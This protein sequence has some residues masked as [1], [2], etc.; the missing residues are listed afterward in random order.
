MPKVTIDVSELHGKYEDEVKDL[1]GLLKSKA[2]GRV[3][4]IGSE[5]ILS[6]EE[7]EKPPAKKYLRVLIRKFLH[8]AELKESFRVISGREIDFII[9]ERRIYE[10][11]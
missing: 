3:E 11:E 5:V 9:K 4:A 7:D 2:G 6:Y 10:A 8:R 1:V